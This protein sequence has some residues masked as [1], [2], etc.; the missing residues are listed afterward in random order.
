[1][2]PQLV[3]SAMITR[4]IITAMIAIPSQVIGSVGVDSG[5]EGGSLTSQLPRMVAPH[6]SH[7]TSDG[8][9]SQCGQAIIVPPEKAPEATQSD[10][11]QV[12]QAP[13]ELKS[14]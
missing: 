14:W 8:P 12:S 6:F 1:M 13:R 7:G 2:I 5:S 10:R 9:R 3:T 4:I 11:P